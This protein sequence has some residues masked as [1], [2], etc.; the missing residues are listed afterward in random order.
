MWAPLHYI[1]SV[2]Q[3]AGS[4]ARPSPLLTL[5][6]PWWRGHAM[7]GI[8][9]FGEALLCGVRYFPGW[10]AAQPSAGCR[11]PSSPLQQDFQCSKLSL[12]LC[13]D[14]ES[15][16]SA[17]FAVFLMV[18]MHLSQT[19]GGS[20]WS[21]QLKCY[22]SCWHAWADR[23]EPWEDFPVSPRECCSWKDA[24]LLCIPSLTGHALEASDLPSL[25]RQVENM[26][27]FGCIHRSHGERAELWR[28]NI[29]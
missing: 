17:P 26:F 8:L 27:H 3:S 2:L 18:L 29:Q 9:C 7:Q 21:S 22:V 1:P 16:Q 20:T 10:Q 6:G 4:C 25:S 23:N 28:T 11:R 24:T 13:V 14:P 12:I 5:G 15:M 19:W